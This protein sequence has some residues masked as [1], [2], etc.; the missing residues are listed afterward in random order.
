MTTKY[1]V[2]WKRKHQSDSCFIRIG[3]S[4]SGYHFKDYYEDINE[5]FLAANRRIVDPAFSDNEYCIREE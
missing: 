5:A 3:S 1:Q 4:G 2:Y